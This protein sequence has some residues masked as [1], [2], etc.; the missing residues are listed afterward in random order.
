MGAMPQGPTCTTR[1]SPLLWTLDSTSAGKGS[2]LS[3][4]LQK[5]HQK[6]GRV[7]FTLFHLLI[8]KALSGRGFAG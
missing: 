8:I 3:W 4:F 1:F 6:P 5:A 2:F 7:C